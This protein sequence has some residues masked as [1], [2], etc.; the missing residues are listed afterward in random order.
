[1]QY[2]CQADRFFI[3]ICTL[4][5]LVK[6]PCH[7][8]WDWT[9][10]TNCDSICDEWSSSH[11]LK[12]HCLQFLRSNFVT[13]IIICVC[14]LS[15]SNILVGDTTFVDS[16]MT[17]Y[18]DK[19]IWIMKLLNL[20]NFL[21]PSPQSPKHLTQNTNTIDSTRVQ[22][23]Y[24]IYVINSSCYIVWKSTFLNAGQTHCICIFF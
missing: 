24:S 23:N 9:D 20:M 18:A 6:V 5:F 16:K 14:E 17:G 1:M 12:F 4:F 19:H 21:P 13:F 15:K 3:V 2:T 11:N 8:K 10:I 7:I 22:L